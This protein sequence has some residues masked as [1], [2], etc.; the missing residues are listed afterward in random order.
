MESFYKIR[1]TTTGAETQPVISKNT[2]FDEAD[3]PL[4]TVRPIPQAGVDYESA[5]ERV[6]DLFFKTPGETAKSEHRRQCTSVRVKVLIVA[7]LAAGHTLDILIA[8]PEPR[9][10][11]GLP[12]NTAAGLEAGPIRMLRPA[13]NML[14]AIR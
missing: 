13:W 2:D 9:E 12:V 10:W 8:I 14:G 7:A 6:V 1:R 11:D 5:I 3:A 4:L